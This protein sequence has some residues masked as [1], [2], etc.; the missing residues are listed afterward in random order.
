MAA[1]YTL[2]LVPKFRALGLD[3]TPLAGGVVS[4]Y[5][6]GSTTPKTSY[7]DADMASANPWPVVLDA[8]GQAGIWVSGPYRIMVTDADGV[9]QYSADHLF[10]FGGSYASMPDQDPDKL[11]AWGT[12]DGTLINS[13]MSVADIEAAVRA[14]NTV[15]MLAGG[16]VAAA[17]GDA[18]A[19]TLDDKLTVGPGLVKTVNT[20]GSGV[21]RLTVSLN[22]PA[23]VMFI[24]QNFFTP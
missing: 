23:S 15:T 1:L 24:T 17:A 21:K 8:N 9:Q 14:F 7:A 22:D 6:A 2:L 4:I 10:G 16:L 11:I 5:E 12:P 20:D 19:G 18:S 3:G 13:N